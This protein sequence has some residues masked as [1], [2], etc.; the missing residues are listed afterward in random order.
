MNS[1]FK[2]LPFNSRKTFQMKNFNPNSTSYITNEINKT[3][4]DSFNNWGG[5]TFSDILSN[6]PKEVIDNCWLVFSQAII[7]N[8]LK[9]KGT[10]IKNFGT[11]TFTNEEYS[12]EG[13]TNQYKR[14]IKKR[15]PIFI[16]S[17]DFIDYL[18][19][20]I[21][22][23]KYGLIYNTQ[24]E[25]KNISIIKLNLTK[26]SL[27]LN[28]SKEEV[29]TIISSIIKNMG[30]SIRR[31]EFKGKKINKIGTFLIKNNIFGVKFEK[32]FIEE[33]S[34]KSQK[35]YHIKKNFKLC[36][37]TKD[38]Q[39]IR[40]RN[41]NDIDKAEREIRP[42]I[43][44]ITKVSQSADRWLKQN[45]DIDIR[46]D[47]G[48]D[49]YDYNKNNF[50]NTVRHSLNIKKEKNELLVDQRYYRSY[51]R[52]SLFGLKIPQDILEHI[53]NNKNLLIRAMKQI[54]K[55]GDGIIPKFE[56]INAFHKQNVHHALR[57][58]LIE[59]IVDIYLDNDPN[60]IM[61]K[62]EN[63][64]RELCKDIKYIIDTEYHLFPINKYK[65]TISPENKRTVS[66]SMF[67]RDTGNLN[68]KAI[69]SLRKYIKL[70]KIK[71]SDIKDLIE[72]ICK[73][74]V[75][76]RNKYN[77]KRMISY[78][79]LKEI[80]EKENIDINKEIIVSLLKYFDIEN[81]NCFHI[82]E[83]IDKINEKMMNSTAFNFRKGYN[84]TNNNTLD[85]FRGSKNKMKM[86]YD[87][88][89]NNTQRL[90][91]KNKNPINISN[92]KSTILPQ[93]FNNNAYNFALN[94]DDIK[95]NDEE[96]SNLLITRLIKTIK[97]RIYRNG[98]KVDVISE[99]FDHLLSYNICRSEN[100]IYPDELERLFQLEKFNFSI[101]EI[102]SIFNFIDTKKDGFI[103]RI[104]FINAIRNVPHPLT[105]FINFMKNNKVTIADIAYKIGYDIYNNSINE[106]LKIKLNK[107]SFQTRMKAV[108]DSFDNE[109]IYGLFNYI[110][111]GKTE[112]TVGQ[113]FDAINYN[114]DESYKNLS[115]KKDEIINICMNI[116]PKNVS[117]S[118][119]KNNFLKHD[120]RLKYEI[121]IDNFLNI[122]KKYL[123]QKINPEYYFHFLRIYN[124]INNKN[125]VNYQ[126]FLMQIYK[127]CKDDLWMKSLEAF[128][129]FLKK[130]C[131]N[132]LFIFIVKIN[133]LSN[134]IS[135]KQTVDV[136]RM[137]RFI[138]DR[139]RRE[140]DIQ[141][142]LK[143]DYNNDGI[144]SMED[145][146]N[147]IMKYIDKNYFITQEKRE[148]NMKLKEMKRNKSMNK[149]LFLELKKILNKLN[150]TEDNLFFFLDKK[151]DNVLDFEE[152]KTQLPLL[153]KINSSEKEKDL[154]I[155]F[156]YL[157]EYK[158]KKVDIN[159]FRNKLR[160][161][162]DE[163]KKNHENDYVGN[164]TI[165]NLLLDEF[166]KW[167]K[168]NNNLSDTEL[169]P[170]LDHDHD[171]IISIN[172][173]KYFA[174]KILF[175]PENELNDTKILHFIV[176]LSLTNSKYLVL[177]D[178]Q[179]IMK[180]IKK[181]EIK[182]YENNIYNYCNEGI[183]EKA[184]DK[185]W[186]T[187]V[188]DNIGM[189]ISEIYD[190]D[191]KKFYDTYNTTNYRNQGQGLSFDN[192]SI[193]LDRNYQI[194]EQYH[195]NKIQQKIIFN[196][197]SQNTNYITLPML[198]KIFCDKKY[199]F[200]QKMHEEITK[201]LHENYPTSEDAFKFFHSVKTFKQ[202]T[203]TYNDNISGN[204]YITKQEFFNGINKM[205]PN[206]Y[207]N[208]TFDKYFYKLFSNKH[209][210]N[211]K[212]IIIKF[213]EFNYIY[214]SDLKLDNYFLKS[215]KKDSK[216]LTTR[217]KPSIPFTSFLSPFEVKQHELFETPYDLDPL[218]KIKKLILSSKIDFKK[219]FLNIIKES[220]NGMANQFEFRNIIKRF[221]I[222][223]TNI[224][225]EDIIHKSGMSSDGKINLVDFIIISS[226][227]IR[228]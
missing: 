165:E 84:Q 187:S 216:I 201:F 13:T 3:A 59:K 87:Y 190:N 127:D 225:I 227:K 60:L 221:D 11:F 186:I 64:I 74:G 180:N 169:F 156:D 24:S 65:Y 160:L 224:E 150:M 139:I 1:S 121:S 55:H 217:E 77:Y 6:Y 10:F 46:K 50:Y 93:K 215:L 164:S 116:I 155:F 40:Q 223:L 78:L 25:N 181:D 125:I 38:C 184:K 226:M 228:I 202:E 28:I 23:D 107:L 27:A 176:A 19:P 20:G 88:S 149:A 199:N 67:S 53:Y 89:T 118:E 189:F 141:T 123:G 5:V 191:L 35:L 112:I 167:L 177:A 34:E 195:I 145:L 175:M 79:E 144:I 206:K 12:L 192:F 110:S 154:K 138:R 143:F 47:I 21:Y 41:I 80:L 133:N 106:Y 119:L 179:N 172:D 103:D 58:E 30:D 31:M 18:K 193:F 162:N 51:P 108:N 166:S 117:F 132:D 54:D 152:F 22:S 97:D 99:Y 129:Y 136:D 218:L 124:L 7:E 68:P 16:V 8:Y 130:E 171:G 102:N 146:K 115:E 183:T 131:D 213:S 148:E 85:S 157:D 101:P 62:Y 94:E 66:Q 63:L 86:S 200:Y 212:E 75:I 203:P 92:L 142:I 120:T 39:G 61:V 105:T 151:K 70:P 76:L 73:I 220:N 137:Q 32:D 134:N 163:I 95:N 158:T 71:E 36:M 178:V 9:G 135:I 90:A 52:Q 210:E 205:F 45:M 207:K 48:E 219:E 214:F 211:A 49:D 170:I 198:E 17:K 168:I 29:Y 104:E 15:C 153:L 37:E 185:K 57:I 194:L 122:M 113:F 173:I 159:T 26:I 222:G 114:N 42:K 72:R 209:F 128:V 43:A 33:I 161:F 147:I 188:I 98:T 182:N 174:N 204:I 82:N 109:F 196:H 14:D 197:I 4:L 44:P 111:E 208:E 81:P 69:S 126:K 140:V 100:I 91:Q 56:F 96:L 83:F 2:Q